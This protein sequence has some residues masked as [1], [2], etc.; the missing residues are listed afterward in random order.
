[1]VIVNLFVVPYQTLLPVFA[2]DILDTGAMGLGFL[3]MAAGLGAIIGS[4]G[5]ANLAPR[6]RG[7][8][9]FALA[10]AASLATTGFAFSRLFALSI[11]MLIL[12]SGSV[13]AL[14]VLTITI[15]QRQVHDDLRGRVMSVVVLFDAGVPRLG[16]LGAGYLA[17]HLGAPQSLGLGALGC[18]VGGLVL[19][20][21]APQLRKLP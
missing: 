11:L 14:K 13:V 3:T 4:L 17:M 19:S 7:V 18:V 21:M 12:V 1:M 6:R 20:L 5:V 8:L 10:V 16:G 9:V 2:R 15:V